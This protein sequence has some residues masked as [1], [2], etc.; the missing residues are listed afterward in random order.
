M[1]LDGQ[2]SM[3]E[4]IKEMQNGEDPKQLYAPEVIEEFETALNE[5]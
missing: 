1:Q 4:S 2:R 3:L 5:K